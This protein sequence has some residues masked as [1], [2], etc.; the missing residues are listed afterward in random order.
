MV[1]DYDYRFEIYPD[2]IQ[3]R[4]EAQQRF[5]R[6]L[7]ERIGNMALEFVIETLKRW[8]SGQ[9]L[10]IA[11]KGGTAAL[12][13]KIAD[14]ATEWTN[15]ANLKFDFGFDST[16]GAFRAWSPAD[17][18]YAADVRISFDQPG[19]WSLVGTDS[20]DPSIVNP[21]QASMNFGGYAVALP[22][23]W[24]GTVLHEFGHALGFQHEHQ[25]PVG[26]CDL[27]FRWEDDPAYL[28]TVDGFGQFIPDGDGKR[29]GIYTVLGGPPNRWPQ[30]KVDHNLRQLSNA[31]AFMVSAFDPQSIMKYYFGDWMF[32]TGTSSHCFSQ[33]NDVLSDL[34]KAG[35]ASAY[36][37]AHDEMASS[38]EQKKTLLKTLIDDQKLQPQVRESYELRLETLEES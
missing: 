16:A 34:D 37:A 8:N 13:K 2:E 18:S 5:S 33:R 9:T 15:H 29:P 26:G 23:A 12:H 35:A 38:L 21:S 30:A 6:N 3:A 25:T 36:P 27:D 17:T 28:P 14:V 1:I 11:F 19:Y 10:T 22:N 32:R 7:P 20:K 31:H 4:L 24:Q